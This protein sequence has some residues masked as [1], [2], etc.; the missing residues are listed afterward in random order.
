MRSTRPSIILLS[1]ARRTRP[2][3]IAVAP[4]VM[5]SIGVS[6]GIGLSSRRISSK[7]SMRIVAV[8]NILPKYSCASGESRDR[9]FTAVANR[10]YRE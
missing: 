4:L 7:V 9:V 8:A 3:R 10:W 5:A 1:D 2:S 6:V